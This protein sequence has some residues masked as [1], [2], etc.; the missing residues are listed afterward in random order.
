[1]GVIPLI[2]STH[3]PVFWPTV[4]YVTDTTIGMP[5]LKSYQDLEVKEH[6]LGPSIRVDQNYPSINMQI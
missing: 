6:T 4:S 3:Y 2:R 1:M 5:N